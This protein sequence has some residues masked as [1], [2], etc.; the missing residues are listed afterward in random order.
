MKR[1]R[2]LL[3]EDDEA[4]AS[5]LEEYLLE[6]NYDVTVHRRGDTALESLKQQ[7]FDLVLTDIVM[8]GADGLTLLRHVVHD[9]HS[10]TLVIL[11]T[12]YS[13]I[14]NALKFTKQGSVSF[15]YSIDADKIKFYVKDTGIGIGEKD[16]KIIFERFSQADNEYTKAGTGTGLGLSIAKGLVELLGGTIWLENTL[17]E[18]TTFIFTIPLVSVNQKET[19]V[20]IVKEDMIKN[21][22][23]EKTILVAEDELTNFIYIREVLKVFN[24]KIIRAENGQEAVDLFNENKDINLI[25]M[26]IKM[27]ILNGYEATLEIRKTSTT[28]PIIAVTAYAMAEDEALAMK[29]GCNEYISKPVSKGLLYN[30]IK[31]YLHLDL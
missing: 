19:Y 10:D 5:L 23:E 6:A 20:S 29:A 28:I 15:G 9:D 31:K 12:G 8:P 18:G 3:A 25:L 13:G 26:D 22:T 30:V 16:K 1:P 11:M 27:P 24:I 17:T 14:E 7:Q 2:L 4:L 21:N